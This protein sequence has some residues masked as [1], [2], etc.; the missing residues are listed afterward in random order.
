LPV[1][2]SR[3][4]QNNKNTPKR[5]GGGKNFYFPPPS[6]RSYAF[7]RKQ[8]TLRGVPNESEVVCSGSINFYGSH[9]Q[10]AAERFV[11]EET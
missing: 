11:I 1:L 9:G 10:G 7:T 2:T 4:F 6:P 8:F 3:F 5:G